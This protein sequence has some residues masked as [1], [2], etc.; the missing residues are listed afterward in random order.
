MVEESMSVREEGE[1]A[2]TGSFFRAAAAGRRRAAAEAREVPE[3]GALERRR[4]ALPS[5]LWGL[6]GG[7]K[8]GLGFLVA[9]RSKH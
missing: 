1:W 6:S 8:S 9:D 5:R 4:R 2:A 7:D 3:R